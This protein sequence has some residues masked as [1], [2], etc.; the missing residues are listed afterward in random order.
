MLNRRYYESNV[1]FFLSKH[2]LVHSKSPPPNVSGNIPQQAVILRHIRS[3]LNLEFI[4]FSFPSVLGPENGDNN[5]FHIM[6]IFVS[7][8]LTI[9]SRK[10]KKKKNYGK[11]KRKILSKVN[12]FSELYII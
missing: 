1:Y 11:E 12:H 2:L 9:L 4:A 3:T 5:I 7:Q 6:T 10:R 8:I